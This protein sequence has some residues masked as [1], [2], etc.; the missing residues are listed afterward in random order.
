MTIFNVTYPPFTQVM[1]DTDSGELTPAWTNY[2]RSVQ[3]LLGSNFNEKGV[4]I[5]TLE[6]TDTVSDPTNGAMVYSTTE[7]KFKVYED[8][9]WKTMDTT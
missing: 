3:N 8:G 2:F 1:I 4:N 9:T 5:P 6:S 7:N